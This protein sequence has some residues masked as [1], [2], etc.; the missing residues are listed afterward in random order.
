MKKMKTRFPALLLALVIAV[1]PLMMAVPVSA[2]T[3]E[4][5]SYNG[6]V[7]PKL[8]T[9]DSS[10][11]IIGVLDGQ[12]YLK[13]TDAII[14]LDADGTFAFRSSKDYVVSGNSWVLLDSTVSAVVFWANT[15]LRSASSGI[16]VE[17]SEPVVVYVEVPDQPVVLNIN[18]V[19]SVFSGVGSW[20]A[21]AV[22][23][24]TTMFWTAE[25][26]LSVLGVL[27][28][29]ALALAFVLLLIWLIAG[30]LKFK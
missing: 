18:D 29:A 27:T 7:L 14:T 3:V 20:L 2:A 17:A 25:G 13:L 28:V 21:G 11:A 24:M 12:Y 19:L 23:S 5:Y 4:Q 9:S 8:P 30:W 26:G 10:Y 1:M 6:V 15:N 22:S 16:V